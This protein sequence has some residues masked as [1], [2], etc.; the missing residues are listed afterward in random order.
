[1]KDKT[2]IVLE[3]LETLEITKPSDLVLEKIRKLISE[4]ILASG[5]QLPPERTLSEKFG[6]GRGHIREAIKKLEFYGIVKTF[7]QN[8]TFVSDQGTSL[9]EHMISNIIK[10][11]KNDKKALI[12]ARELLE[13]N[14]AMLAAQRANEDEIKSLLVTLEA[15]QKAVKS[16]K[17]GLNEDL[18]FHL[19][20]AKIS[21]NSII[22][23]MIMLITPQVHKFSESSNSCRNGRAL[24]AYLEHESIFDAI[25]SH[26]VNKA[27]EAMHYHFEN[28]R[29]S[30]NIE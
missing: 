30:L 17:N 11:E 18:I 19:E 21:G 28:T 25:A 26:N 3:K 29:Q 8:G 6:I 12:E 4:G 20:I 24:D 15:H 13:V 27:R 16:N 23:S 9:L 1:M 14:A 2:H 22:H 7:P 10:L 5:D